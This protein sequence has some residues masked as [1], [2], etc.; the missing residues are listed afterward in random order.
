MDFFRSENGWADLMPDD[1]LEVFMDILQG[2]SDL[3]A[4]LLGDLLSRYGADDRLEVRD[5][6]HAPL[7]LLTMEDAEAV[8]RE[9]GHDPTPNQLDEMEHDIRKGV[10][11][12]LGECWH[13]VMKTACENAWQELQ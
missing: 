8:L 10:E 1:R 11:W 9:L 6:E 3:T 2:D 4:N 5:K 12:G 7:H 13:E